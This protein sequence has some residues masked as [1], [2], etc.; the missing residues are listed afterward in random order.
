MVPDPPEIEALARRVAGFGLPG[1]SSDIGEV[2]A[3]EWQPFLTLLSAE[4]LTGLAEAARAAGSLRLSE[5]QSEELRSCHRDA[6]VWSL[7]IEQKLARLGTAFAEEAISFVVLKGPA[8]ANSAYP[9]PSLRPFG[10]VD[11]LVGTAD[12]PRACGLLEGLGYRRQLP[13]PRP[14]F[15][16]R[17][18]KAAVWGDSD[19][20]EVDLHRTLVVG[21]HG[22][23]V[24]P[25][26]LLGRTVVF[27]LGGR[28]LFRLDDTTMLLHACMHAVLGWW[29]PLMWTL[30]D[31]AQVAWSG[32]VDWSELVR[33][34]HRWR[35]RAVLSEALRRTTDTLQVSLPTDAAEATRLE[36]SRTE[37]KALA[38]YITEKR[39]RTG[40]AVSTLAAIP[41]LRHK[42]A[43]IRALVIPS[44]SFLAARSDDGRGSYLRRLMVPLRRMSAR[45]S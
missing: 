31:V 8:V 7:L 36:T 40:P 39:W 28:R 27:S 19:S 25:Q 17:F 1:R 22:L 30:R 29:P 5:E 33:L 13:E 43:Y 44:R 3:P 2:A 4:R 24:G 34:A 37:R 15:D 23:W 20:I 42:L 12:W 9:D 11:L 32:Q 14:G 6:M 16:Q 21:P 38:A 18:G 10:D 45:K 35:L 26:E 41:G